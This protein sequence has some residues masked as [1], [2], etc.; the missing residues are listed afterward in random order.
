[1][2]SRPPAAGVAP[3][4]REGPAR[5]QHARD[6]AGRT[7]PVEPVPGVADGDGI[8]AGVR[9][10]DRLGG[11][12]EDLVGLDQR[13]HRGE[14]LHGHHGMPGRAQRLRELAGAGRQI[15]HPGPGSQLERFD[16]RRRVARAGR[17]VALA[18]LREAGRDERMELPAHPSAAGPLL[19]SGRNDAMSKAYAE[20]LRV[21]ERAGLISRG[22][23]TQRRPSRLEGAP[24]EAAADWLAEYRGAHP[25]GRVGLGDLAGQPRHDAR[26]RQFRE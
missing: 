16:H 2:R 22:R 5:P 8:D 6:L 17:V 26:G 23:E 3:Q 18:V 20:D 19:V 24:L 1:M 7:A 9:E 15:E 10:R 12:V 13:A 25:A 21:L 11:A 4:E 14:R